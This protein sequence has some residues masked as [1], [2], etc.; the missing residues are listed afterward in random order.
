[1]KK[2]LVL[3]LLLAL[4]SSAFAGAVSFDGKGAALGAAPRIVY[5]WLA[6]ADDNYTV[7]TWDGYTV[8]SGSGIIGLYLSNDGGN[9]NN[10]SL[11]TVPADKPYTMTTTLKVTDAE[12]P[13]IRLGLM[14]TPN[15]NF[16]TVSAANNRVGFEQANTGNNSYR[17]S[18]LG[19]ELQWNGALEGAQL[20]DINADPGFWGF[21]FFGLLPNQNPYFPTFTYD[22]VDDRTISQAEDFFAGRPIIDRADL[23]GKEFGLK[24]EW[25]PNEIF[26]GY[27][28]ANPTLG[29][30][31]YSIKIEDH[32]DL[33]D[34]T[35]IYNMAV[36][37][38]AQKSPFAGQPW[39]NEGAEHVFT[40]RWRAA[41]EDMVV[42]FEGDSIVSESVYGVSSITAPFFAE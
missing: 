3:A 28:D 6:N 41:V 30:A 15:T 4:T 29:V 19:I 25:N 14:L 22:G 10:S 38:L 23:E 33:G 16:A 42:T 26:T 18:H 5:H 12:V 1:M 40:Y 7:G 21:Q 2:A 31:R 9:T 17:G 24:V 27:W 34:W 36:A 32:E 11:F 37:D 39:M 13:N 35:P 8:A 20:Q